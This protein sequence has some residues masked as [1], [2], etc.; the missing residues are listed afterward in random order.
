MK[1]FEIE[2]SNC[3]GI[4]KNGKPYTLCLGAGI[5]YSIMPDWKQLTFEILK[6]TVDPHITSTKFDQ[7][8]QNIGWSL[9]S[10]LQASLNF[11]LEKGGDVDSFNEL[12]QR[13]LYEKI[14]DN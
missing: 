2:S 1:H 8:L 13:K 7:V 10:M 3:K 11:V 6:E 5:C 12:I 14:T 4:L 9:D